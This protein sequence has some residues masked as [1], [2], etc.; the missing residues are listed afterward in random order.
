[1]PD[2]LTMLQLAHPVTQPLD[3]L[4]VGAQLHLQHTCHRSLVS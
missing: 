3:L 1:M 2:M 4:L